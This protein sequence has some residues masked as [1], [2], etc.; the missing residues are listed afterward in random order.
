MIIRCTR[1]LF[2]M[3]LFGCFVQSSFAQCGLING[4]LTV[5]NTNDDG[6]GSLRWAINCANELEGSN[7]IIF[8]I[9]SNGQNRKNIFVGSTTGEP[10][11]SLIDEGTIIDGSFQPG[12]T[13]RPRIVLDGGRVEWD[14][15]IN[16]LFIVADNCEIYGLEIR[17]FPDDGIDVFGANNVKIGALAKGNVI[18]KCGEERD[19]YEGV[20]PSGPWEGSGI[21]LRNGSSFCEIKSNFIGTDARTTNNLSN[22][23]C[24]ILISGNSNGNLVGGSVFQE[25]NVIAFNPTAIR[26]EGSTQNP[27]LGNSI[28]CNDT[29]A[30]V[31]ANGG[32]N[33][34]TAPSIL[35]ANNRDISGRGIPG[36][37]IEIFLNISRACPEQACQGQLSVGTA[38]VAADST[39][40]FFIAGTPSVG[41]I[42]FLEYDR[43]AATATDADGNTSNFSSCR[44][45]NIDTEN[46]ADANGNIIVTNTDDDGPG[47]LRAAIEC[48]NSTA[49]ANT[50]QFNI[51]GNGPH[52]INVGASTQQ[53]LPTLTDNNTIIDASTQNGF[54]GR[55][56]IVLNG[57]TT[58]WNAPI[59]ALF[60]NGNNCEVY[61]LEIR[62]FPDDGIDIT[63]AN[64]VIIGEAG[65]GNVIYNCGIEQDFWPNIN[66]SGSWEGCGIVVKGGSSNCTISGNIIGTNYN[67]SLS[68]GNEFCGINIGG[69]VRNVLIGGEDTAAGNI[70]TNNP[71]GVLIGTTATSIQL[72]QNS[73][74][75]NDTLAIG[76]RGNANAG[77]TPPVITDYTESIVAGTANAGDLIEVFISSTATCPD[78]ACQGQTF[79]GSTRAGNNG[80]WELQL[81]ASDSRLSLEVVTATATDASGNT[82][83]FADCFTKAEV[84]CDN[85]SASIPQNQRQDVTCGKDN[86]AFVLS[87]TG[88]TAPYTYDIGN[89]PQLSPRFE[90]LARG[91]Y[92]VTI[93][94]ANGCEATQATAINESDP[95]SLII[96]D[97]ENAVCGQ[98]R[99]QFS[100]LAF[101]SVAPYT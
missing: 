7:R 2:C 81:G 37:R 51:A 64:N 30:I 87:V 61:G 68:V 89:G 53:A 25:I 49:G 3:L 76:L 11:P 20:N 59:N 55:P 99:G 58:T 98:A 91:T 60:I 79:L 80:N 5:T 41:N 97:Q 35:I 31:L 93:M 27:L 70:I 66:P 15:P 74:V 57:N 90:N 82:S 13:D 62:N 33:L 34:K 21:A 52:I 45:V 101:G 6:P 88:G 44:I 47:S 10:L 75:C 48:A 18:Y 67:Q 85:F 92:S 73:F 71:T 1:L 83:P 94:D 84:N 78:Q 12:A 4:N 22:E 36:D 23:Y 86:G 40:N 17:N 9:P 43:A 72:H 16:G 8:Q 50:I 32:N 14:A 24:G 42:D 39:W 56:Q 46:C 63:A 29:A 95:L 26:V 38:R 54:S 77:K 69:Q 100:V 96:V 28:V 19:F 65:K